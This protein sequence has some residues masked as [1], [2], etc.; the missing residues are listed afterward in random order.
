MPE[1]KSAGDII[2]AR[3]VRWGVLVAMAVGFLAWFSPRSRGA[4][5]TS[6]VLFLVL[7]S[8]GFGIYLAWCQFRRRK[9]GVDFERAFLQA[10]TAIPEG[11]KD[12]VQL[13]ELDSLQKKFK[14]GFEQFN[15]AVDSVYHVPWYLIIGEPGSG[16]TEA[17]RHSN[18]DFYDGRQESMQGSGGTTNM[19][20]WFVRHS[21]HEA[22]I[23]DTA[24]K[25]VFPEVGSGS[26]ASPQWKA[27]L[28]LIAKHRPRQPINGL[29]L[30]LSVDSLISD[31]AE[32]IRRK[33][34]R[35]F[36][37]LEIIKDNLNVRF[38][39]Y[40][41]VTKCD[42]LTGFREFFTHVAE[43]AKTEDPDLQSQIVGWSNH[44]DR[45]A[46]LRPEQVDQHLEEALRRFRRRRLALLR[47]PL[48]TRGARS[49]RIDEVDALYALPKS[50]SLIAPRLRRYLETI[51]VTGKS[52]RPLFL[53][54]IYFTSAMQVGADMDEAIWAALGRPTETPSELGLTEDQGSSFFLRQVFLEK[55]F[56]EYRLVTRA[57]NTAKELRRRHAVVLGSA[58]LLLLVWLVFAGFGKGMLRETAEAQE[59]LWQ[60]AANADYQTPE[61]YWKPLVVPAKSLN[62]GTA[63]FEYKGDSKIEGLNGKVGLPEFHDS[64]AD[65]ADKP[66]GH[67]AFFLAKWFHKAGTA[68]RREAQEIVFR[69]SV[70]RPLLD[71][72]RSRMTNLV[73]G[74]DV[75]DA[76]VRHKEAL[77]ALIRLEMD[78]AEGRGL[79]EGASNAVYSEYLEPWLSYA[80]ETNFFSGA[81]FLASAAARTYANPGRRTRPAAEFSGGKSLAENAAIRQG[82]DRFLANAQKSNKD[83]QDQ[84]SALEDLRKVA[85]AFKNAEK[86]FGEIL[87]SEDSVQMQLKYDLLRSAYTNLQGKIEG[88]AT[89]P[90]LQ[91]FTK[92]SDSLAGHFGTLADQQR[93]VG[94]GAIGEVA[95]LIGLNLASPTVPAQGGQGLEAGLSKAFE[96]GKQ[97]ATGLYRWGRN[98]LGANGLREEIENKLTNYV[99]QASRKSREPGD[100]AAISELDTNYL[101]RWSS[102]LGEERHFRYR[103]VNYAKAWEAPPFKVAEQL[104]KKWAFLTAQ[105]TN[106]TGMRSEAEKYSGGLKEVFVR[107]VNDLLRKR[108]DSTRKSFV[109]AYHEEASKLLAGYTRLSAE[110]ATYREMMRAGKTLRELED[111]LADLSPVP[112]SRH[113]ELTQL[114]PSVE[115]A[116]K[117]LAA[118][119]VQQVRRFMADRLGFP[120]VAGAGV[121]GKDLDRQAMVGIGQLIP[122]SM[123]EVSG[124][125]TNFPTEELAALKTSLGRV[126]NLLGSLVDGSGR[127]SSYKLEIHPKEN[128]TIIG[129]LTAVSVLAAD[130]SAY[131]EILN[132]Q[133]L[134]WDFPL[135][136][137]LTMNWKAFP[138]S[139]KTT[140]P[141]ESTIRLEPWAALRLITDPTYRAQPD[142]QNPRKY[143]VELPLQYKQ[144]SLVLKAH[145]VFLSA[146]PALTEW[147]RGSEW[148]R[149]PAR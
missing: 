117:S 88:L 43:A 9:A 114:K 68:N 102:S 83:L 38:P 125:A 24:G 10:T 107:S 85:L 36:Q 104:G 13:A 26:A 122:E 6:L 55:V 66:V 116:R 20:W 72:S 5:M 136:A 138:D 14:K 97:A 44:E 103:Y 131:K 144:R 70:L 17:I 86:Q 18:L 92:A 91:F 12:P 81:K 98:K 15:N 123:N 124:V 93:K 56:K 54:G 29:I 118:A 35:I 76:A 3:L 71:A 30:V 67:W 28:K 58:A 42:K 79:G 11:V 63:R 1:K 141:V 119:Y 142:P 112:P 50:F 80:T 82:L 134:D 31:S 100:E 133:P 7:C 41:L 148:P 32:T 149:V 121:N 46:P 106:V 105:E 145:L 90:K 51:F 109:D 84:E 62:Q 140:Y 75:D 48:P 4:I 8:L 40:L 59:K 61:G 115:R 87:A 49:R 27:F 53:R 130:E 74:T 129:S 94:E 120:L 143:T 147:P 25:M 52:G 110:Q 57:R 45:D 137:P 64:L 78:A 37:Q 69:R 146:P 96:D 16:K 135:D 60:V 127:V 126:T 19:D 99:N 95:K 89:N 101:A 73:E 65:A 21:T 23:L 108:L 113:P 111:D 33:A 77:V 132:T 34:S 139:T 2:P 47:E 128:R 39:V 22:V